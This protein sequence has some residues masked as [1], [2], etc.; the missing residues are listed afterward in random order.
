LYS[1]YFLL[2]KRDFLQELI[3][4]K[5]NP[6]ATKRLSQSSWLVALFV[7]SFLSISGCTEQT[8]KGDVQRGE[9]L[10]RGCVMC[11]GTNGISSVS[12]YPSLAGKKEPYLAMQ[13]NAFR[14]GERINMIMAPHAQNLTD[15]GIADLSA[16]FAQLEPKSE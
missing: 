15:E 14:S 1:N 5:S 12:I 2:N 6:R 3:M 10:S 4:K 11:H 16:Y 9:Q 7:F 8:L 13:L